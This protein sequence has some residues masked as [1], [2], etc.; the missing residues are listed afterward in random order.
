M[1][2]SIRQIAHYGTKLL[3][4]SVTQKEV[5]ARLKNMGL[6]LSDVLVYFEYCSGLT[7][8]KIANQH[9]CTQPNIAWKIKKI[10][11]VLG[12]SPERKNAK[13]NLTDLWDMKKI[14]ELSEEEEKGI[15]RIF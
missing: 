15:Q 5:L 12:F 3:G 4:R 7:Q 1:I 11:R 13:N 9:G 2:N 8:E 10:H 6:S 14:Y